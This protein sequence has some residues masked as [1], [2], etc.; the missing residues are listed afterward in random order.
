MSTNLIAVS[1]KKKSGKDLVANIIAYLQLRND[2]LDE[3]SQ[4]GDYINRGFIPHDNYFEYDHRWENKKFAYKL[5]KIVC[6]VTGVSMG[7]LEMS[8]IK[9]MTV[10]EYTGM[11]WTKWQL[12]WSDGQKEYFNTFE[13]MKGEYEWIE[14]E[15]SMYK[16]VDLTFR[17]W[18]QLIGTECF[19]NIIHPSIWIK[20]LFADYTKGRTTFVD[21]RYMS[22]CSICGDQFTGD[23]RQPIC[24][25]CVD[26]Y[27]EESN[28]PY[29][30]IS[31]TRFINE[32]DAVL[33]RDG[34][35]IRVNR[36]VKYR[37]PD[38]WKE[39][40]KNKKMDDSFMS[41]LHRTDR[42]M[43]DKLNHPSEVNLDNYNDFNY[44]IDNN[45]D[46]VDLILEV[47]EILIKENVIS[48]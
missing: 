13:E 31:D 3:D 35:V 20:A 41:Y 29:W 5:K 32:G 22:T 24:K 15:P 17:D 45:G 16:K 23:K 37:Y 46:I 21:G 6:L 44:I 27:N 28:Y 34:I 33:E 40:K 10:S 14:T 43:Y 9:S 30:V 36:H 7:E 25:S 11:D 12:E 2:R 1:G 47:N 8:E 26:E 39:F 38:K 19:R 4:M 18:M 48:G 42:E